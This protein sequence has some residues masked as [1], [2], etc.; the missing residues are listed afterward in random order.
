MTINPQ[1]T[2]RDIDS[3]PAIEQAIRRRAEDL[4]KFS[5]DIIFC[6]VVLE[7][8]HRRGH[9]GHQ[10]RCCVDLS[11]RGDD[12]VA[13]R[14]PPGHSAHEDVHVAIRDA[15]RAARRELQD[16]ARRRRRHIKRHEGPPRGRVTRLFQGDGYGFLVAPDGHEVYFHRNSVAGDFENLSIGAEVHFEETSGDQGP[17]A[18]TVTPV[19][20]SGHT[21]TAR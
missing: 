8:P 17:Q 19:G 4:E 11:V 2:F 21:L 14:N 12:L 7:R 1:I 20:K 5:D 3:S 9:Q 18:S 10:Y 15:F 6:R 16:Y 13:G